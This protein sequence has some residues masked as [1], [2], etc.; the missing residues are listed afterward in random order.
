MA[1]SIQLC[2]IKSEEDMIKCVAM[3]ADS[4]IQNR[5]LEGKDIS[6]RK[7]GCVSAILWVWLP[8]LKRGNLRCGTPELEC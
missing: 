8:R 3:S 6:S 2:C 7:E 1:S 5:N 4:A